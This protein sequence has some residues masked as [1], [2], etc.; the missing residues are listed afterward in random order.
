MLRIFKFLKPYRFRVIMV[1]VLTMLGV[2]SELYL[3]RL[4]AII[5]DKGI[6][7]EDMVFVYR[8]GIIML[9]VALFGTIF[10]LIASYYSAKTSTGFSKDLRYSVFQKVE[11]F[12]LSELD[13]IGT[14]SLITRTTNDIAQ[15]Q[16]AAI[17]SLR[18]MIR[19]P[20]MLIG[21]LVMATT[22]NV[23]LSKVL[24]YSAPVLI[25]IIAI[26]GAKGFPLF[27]QVQIKIDD[28]NR[29]L[30]ENLTGIRVIR[31]F[32]KGDYEKRRYKKANKELTDTS[33][34]VMRIMSAMMP[35]VSII[36]NLT[37]LLVMWRGSHLVATSDLEVG[38]LMAF[39]QYV[40]MIM[41]SLIMV[42][43][44]F[45]VMPRAIASAQ[46]VNE[47]LEV[48]A[49]IKD[50]NIT[51]LPY[52][53]SSSLCFENVSFNYKNA[54]A[55]AIKAIS[56]CAEKGKS[57]AIVGGTGSGKSTILK[58]A[59]RFYD[60]SNGKI[61]LNG[62][63]IKDL[64]QKAL[65]AQF[66]FMPQ[67]ALLFSGSIRDNI[68]MGND[69]ATDGEIIEAL[70]LAQIYDFVEKNE[71]GLDYELSQGGR[72]LS[73]GQ[74]QR[75]AIARALVRKPKLLLFDDS[76]SALDFKTDKNL[77]AAIAP[78]SKQAALIVVAQRV[79]TIIDFDEIIVLDEGEIVGKGSHKELIKTSKIYRE[80]VQSQLGEEAINE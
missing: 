44:V 75:F 42:S 27:K 78:M 3:P 59:M 48:E 10:K 33:L 51:E 26:I 6:A 55:S 52:E 21:G 65:R 66:G 16:Q 20:L 23:E 32:N 68:K 34:K 79:G 49:E 29:V 70:K 18:M 11:S 22:G 76:F 80:I 50:G 37:I 60:P 13:T 30:R 73:G 71:E 9:L 19:A 74:K 57:L 45:V 35:S 7:N 17:M 47:I 56:F 15:L 43:I 54:E 40:S 53:N 46:R 12:S 2:F 1:I 72:N 36:L 61:T 58:L 5:V 38:Q 64:T 25:L 67:K 28:I 69:N 24:F 8:T 63:D 14:A 41:F 62:V 39:I 4:M 31:A 77:R